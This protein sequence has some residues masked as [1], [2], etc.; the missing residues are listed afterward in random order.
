MYM[1]I[2]INIYELIY[3]HINMYEL[4]YEHINYIQACESQLQKAELVNLIDF[5]S[6]KTNLATEFSQYV[7]VFE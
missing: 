2:N 4:I 6:L 1:N 7:S 3:E 5:L